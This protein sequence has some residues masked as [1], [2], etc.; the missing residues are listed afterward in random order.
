MRHPWMPLLAL[1]AGCG[2]N[3]LPSQDNVYLDSALWDASE[4]IPVEGGLYIRLPEARGLAFVSTDGSHQPVDLGPQELLRAYASPDALSV[5]AFTA[6]YTCGE[7]KRRIDTKEECPEDELDTFN[8][9]AIVQEGEVALEVELPSPYNA[10]RFSEEGRFL[11]AFLDQEGG[12]L[13]SGGVISMTNILVVDLQ[14][15]VASTV[16]VGFAATE[17]LFDNE[18]SR[19]VVLSQNEVA[20]VDMTSSPPATEVTFGLTL[21]A[22]EVVIPVGIELTPSG[23]HALISVEG[24]DSLYILN[25]VNP[26]VNITAL[27]GNPADMVVDAAVDRTVLVYGDEPVADVIEHDNFELE[28]IELDEPMT[29]VLEEEELLLLYSDAGG[30]DVYILRLQEEEEAIRQDLVELRLQQAPESMH[31]APTGDL[32]IALTSD[33]YLGGRYGMEVLD[34]REGEEAS[35]PYALEGRGI[36]LAFA[37]TEDSVEA[38]LLQSDVD[39]LFKLDLNTAEA[40]QLELA[41]PAVAIG[42]LPSGEFYITHDIGTGLVTFLDP[43]TGA[44]TEVSGFATQGLLSPTELLTDP[45]EG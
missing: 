28:S 17:I 22:D 30:R 43:N 9:L 41:A 29:R 34:L 37:E 38:L 39:Y 19:A 2:W 35:Y 15:A 14:E 6:S 11:V 45:E 32:A 13:G 36:G 44:T 40:E 27:S 16:P 8:S 20:V 21:D 23:E 42:A 5:A 24:D 10:V 12:G 3:N 1:L 26:S 18:S 25:L 33:G 4:T 7:D 31:L